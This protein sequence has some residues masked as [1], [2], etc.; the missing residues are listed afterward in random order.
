MAIIVTEVIIIADTIEVHRDKAIG[1]HIVLQDGVEIDVI[2]EARQWVVRE[3]GEIEVRIKN[4]FYCILH[5][6]FHF[7]RKR[8]R[9]E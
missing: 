8:T 2:T 7:G 4:N 3:I 6:F 9:S 5:F 1:I